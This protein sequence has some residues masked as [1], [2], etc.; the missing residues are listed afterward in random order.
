MGASGHSGK[1]L[2]APTPED[3]QTIQLIAAYTGTADHI[4]TSASKSDVEFVDNFGR[5]IIGSNTICRHL[6]RSSPHSE[7]LL[8]ADAETAAVVCQNFSNML[9]LMPG[10]CR[11]AE[12]RTGF[13]TVHSWV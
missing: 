10:A 12:Q 2:L 13:Q 8:G 1:R 5:S 9:P 4:E 3:A 11:T 6:A 7:A